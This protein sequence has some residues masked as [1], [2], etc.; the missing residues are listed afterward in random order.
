M[1]RRTAR[2]CGAPVPRPAWSSIPAACLALALLLAAF[3]APAAAKDV[4]FLSGRIVDEAGMIPQDEVQRLE[5]K[6]AK[7]EQA[8]GDQ[9]AV[10]TVQSL[11]GE[12]LE[13]Y[14]M[15]VAQTWK[16]GQK[17]KDN[18]V[19]LLI[20][21]SDRKLRIEVG[22]GLEPQL[23]DAQAGRI[24]RNVITPRFKAGDFGGGIEAGVDSIAGTLQGQ[25]GAIPE[26]TG[27]SGHMRLRDRFLMGG[28]FFVVIGI[29]SLVALFGKGCQSWFLYAFLMPFYFSFP[30]AIFGAGGAVLGIVW[31]VLFP[32]FKIFVGRTPIGRRWASSS[33]FYSGL[34][35]WVASSSRGGGG[36]SSG[37][38]GFSGGGGSFGGGGASGGW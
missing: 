38:G 12:P 5:E 14:S 19:L 13:D 31:V 6:L 27:P 37:G 32:L 29:F 10:L 25:P 2:L 36:W 9:V 17:G 15:K 26:D 8:T 18:G 35:T 7:L 28:I 22:Y 11:D 20:A 33:P 3:S 34:S 24:I 23:T 16:L 4:P 30:L 1:R 21:K